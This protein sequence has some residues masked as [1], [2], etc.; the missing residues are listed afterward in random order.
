MAI[1][2][3]PSPI[4]NEDNLSH[5]K[6]SPSEFV[7]SVS[8]TVSFSVIVDRLGVCTFVTLRETR[9]WSSSS[10]SVF[11][12]ATVRF[13]REIELA[14]P[15]A[16]ISFWSVKEQSTW[17]FVDHKG[18]TTSPCKRSWASAH[19]HTHRHTHTHTHSYIVSCLP[20]LYKSINAQTT[21]N[22]RSQLFDCCPDLPPPLEIF[23]LFKFSL[24]RF[25]T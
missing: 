13:C 4:R 8:V 3:N 6:T 12:V 10:G 14:S 20:D 16:S 21:S 15:P 2:L 1:S 9:L 7:L 11:F 24:Q 22:F 18:K 25:H 19:T 23:T 5:L 17:W